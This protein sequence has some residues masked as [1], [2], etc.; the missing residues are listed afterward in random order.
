MLV[1]VLPRDYQDQNCS[2]ARTLEVLGDRWT[3]LIV[4]DSLFTARRF[5]DY[6]QRLQIARNVLSDR[7]ARLTEEGILERV[8]YQ[9]RPVRHEYRST[10]KGRDLLPVIVAMIEWGD[11]YH[12]PDGPPREVIHNDCGGHIAQQLTCTRCDLTVRA[13]DVFTRPGPGAHQPTAI[14]S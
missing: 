13:D 10:Q 7:L 8:P 9:Q 14:A 2:I 5:D 11:R 12:A 6:L 3:L 1:A 4:R